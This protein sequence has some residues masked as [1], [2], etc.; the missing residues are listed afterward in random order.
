MA[1]TL[2]VANLAGTL[3][4]GTVSNCLAVQPISAHYRDQPDNT[5][6]PD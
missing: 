4:A 3:A 6:V 5:P 1:A 2:S